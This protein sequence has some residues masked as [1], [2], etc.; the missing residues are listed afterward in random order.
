[1]TG[2]VEVFQGVLVRAGIATADLAA[3]QTHPQVCPCVLAEFRA[4]LAFA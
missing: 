3:G 1:M 4:R 2:L